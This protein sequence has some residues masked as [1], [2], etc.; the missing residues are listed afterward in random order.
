MKKKR[1]L[2]FS[3]ARSRFRGNAGVRWTLRS[4]RQ[5]R[6]RRHP[7]HRRRG[8]ERRRRVRRISYAERLRSSSPRSVRAAIVP[9]RPSRRK[10]GSAR[11]CSA[12][13]SGSSSVIQR[14]PRRFALKNLGAPGG[15]R[16]RD[17]KRSTVRARREKTREALALLE[18]DR[19]P[20]FFSAGRRGTRAP[21][22]SLVSID[23]RRR[24]GAGAGR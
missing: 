15:E 21:P 11:N 5:R 23:S 24:P 22:A 8:L 12:A 14:R 19:L 4:P 18:R 17:R 16:E 6:L 1:S 9:I 3:P 10:T 2:D 7:S 13:G 20:P